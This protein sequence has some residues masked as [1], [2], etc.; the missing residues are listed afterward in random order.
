MDDPD[1]R[2]YV[3]WSL[4]NLPGSTTAVLENLPKTGELADGSRQ[5]LTSFKTTGYG[6]PCPPS[7]THRYVFRVYALDTLL[8]LPSGAGKAELFKSMEGHVLAQGE[9]TAVYNKP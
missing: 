3:H 8:D 6:G 7:G 2:D 9:L 1:A 4:Y 5:G